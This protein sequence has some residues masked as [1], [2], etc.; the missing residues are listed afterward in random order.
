MERQDLSNEGW[1]TFRKR[2]V[3]KFPVSCVWWFGR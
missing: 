1:R 3:A 2:I